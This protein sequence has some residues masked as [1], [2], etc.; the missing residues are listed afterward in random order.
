[1]QLLE[2][3]LKLWNHKEFLKELKLTADKDY[4]IQ[5]LLQ[6]KNQLLLKLLKVLLK[7]L[8]KRNDYC[9]IYLTILFIYYSFIFYL[10]K[11]NT[12]NLASIYTIFIQLS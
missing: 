3:Y 10:D 9:E 4:I 1:M 12:L 7:E 8:V 6:L 2:F 5:L 11:S